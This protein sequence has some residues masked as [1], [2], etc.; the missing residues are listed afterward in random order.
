MPERRVI[1]TVDR[2]PR[3]LELLA[4]F[5][6]KAGYESVSASRIADFDHA[7]DSAAKIDLALVD[8]AGFD[9][10]IWDRC[11]RLKEAQIPFLI[12]S[13]G[14]PNTVQQDSVTHGARAVLMKP[15]ASKDLLGM[16]RGLLRES[17]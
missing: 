4:G 10:Q 16:I 1:L 7:L 15:L 17:A 3:N 8:L 11:D 2:N 9:H 6:G 13:A 5:L 14:Q 12:I